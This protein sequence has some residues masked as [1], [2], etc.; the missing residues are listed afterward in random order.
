[1]IDE[2]TFFDENSLNAWAFSMPTESFECLGEVKLKKLCDFMAA[3]DVYQQLIIDGF[4]NP[5]LS[6]Y[7]W[8]EECRQRKEYLYDQRYSQFYNDLK[9]ASKLYVYYKKIID[10]ADIFP[11]ESFESMHYGVCG[12]QLSA[13]EKKMLRDLEA[14]KKQELLEPNKDLIPVLPKSK[15]KRAKKQKLPANVVSFMDYKERKTA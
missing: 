2:R 3:F 14:K 4:E 12:Y 6:T 11:V 13:K 7:L 8:S 5:E 9:L 15:K 1:M 10:A